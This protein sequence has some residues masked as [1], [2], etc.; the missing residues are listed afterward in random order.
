MAALH[1][2]ISV[3]RHTLTDLKSPRKIFALATSIRR[4]PISANVF[5]LNFV[6]RFSTPLAML[7]FVTTAGLLIENH[8]HCVLKNTVYMR[9]DI[10][11]LWPHPDRIQLR[12]VASVV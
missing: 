7:P 6:R 3:A 12:F 2:P 4:N 10:G 5:R 1:I 8:V 9:T 11:L